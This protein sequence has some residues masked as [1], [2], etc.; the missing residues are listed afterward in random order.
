MAGPAATASAPRA[1]G[2][3]SRSCARTGW[4]RAWSSASRAS[5]GPAAAGWSPSSATALARSSAG[6]GCAPGAPTRSSR[7]S[8]PRRRPAGAARW[9]R[10]GRSL[11]SPSPRGPSGP[12]GPRSPGVRR[13][14]RSRSRLRSP[15]SCPRRRPPGRWRAQRGPG[16]GASARASAASS[17][18]GSAR[19][20]AGARPRAWRPSSRTTSRPGPAALTSAT[21]CC[22]T[23]AARG[24]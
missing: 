4:R 5:C 8:G 10:A 19:T 1:T 20:Q 21:R 12:K 11:R 18:L 16:T 17:W 3:S 23:V 13:P 2:S 22:R 15:P 14:W 9:W 6:S 24:R 7:A